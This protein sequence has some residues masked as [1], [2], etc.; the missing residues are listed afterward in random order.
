MKSSKHA[1]T[2]QI[3]SR[4]NDVISD[5]YTTKI[6]HKNSQSFIVMSSSVM[7]TSCSCFLVHISFGCVIEFNLGSN[8]WYNCYEALLVVSEIRDGGF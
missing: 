2:R 1:I 4:S 6:A 3:V 5:C 7:S 8:M